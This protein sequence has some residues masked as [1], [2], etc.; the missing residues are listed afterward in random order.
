VWDR[1]G[2]RGNKLDAGAAPGGEAGEKREKLARRGFAGR[3]EGPRIGHG[4]SAGQ[5]TRESA[6]YPVEKGIENGMEQGSEDMGFGGL[7]GQ[8]W[9]RSCIARPMI[10]SVQACKRAS[11]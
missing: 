1:R 9:T 10:T 3:T 7:V 5:P 4:H 8:K 2:G 6:R 11:G